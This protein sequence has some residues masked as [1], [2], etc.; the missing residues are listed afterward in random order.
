MWYAGLHETTDLCASPDGRRAPG[1][2]SG[3]ALPRRLCAAP[4]PDSARQ[5]A[6][7]AC[8]THRGSVRLRRPDCPGCAA[9]VQ[10]PGPR[11]AAERLV[12]PPPA[13][14]AGVPRRARR[15]VAHAL[16]PQSAR[17]RPPHQPMDARPGR[18]SQ[19]RRRV[20]PHGGEWRGD[21][22][23]VA[24]VGHWLATRQALDHQPRSRVCPKKGRRDR[25]IALAKAHPD[26]ALG[27]ADEVWWSRLAQPH[28]HAWTAEDQPVRL[29]EQALAPDDPDPK[30]LACYGV[31]L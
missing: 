24:A 29:V 26:W 25:L 3:P 8:A 31:L 30:A 27:F 2:D 13:P 12:A 14:T 6:R 16:A 5:R 28:L 18:R 11:C 23:D 7:R 17:V 4:L 21:P 9:C 22:Q 19:L 20:D 15:A 10:F 1:T